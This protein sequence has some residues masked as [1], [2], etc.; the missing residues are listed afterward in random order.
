TQSPVAGS[1]VGIGTHTISI[2]VTDQ[3]GNSA[4]CSTTLTVEDNTAPEISSASNLEIECDAFGNFELVAEW[5]ASVTA[6]DNCDANVDVTASVDMETLD[7]T[8]DNI[9][10]TTVTW[11]ATDDA[12]NTAQTSAVLIINDARIPTF[13]EVVD[14]TVE[15]DGMGNT[16]EFEMF[17]SQ[18]VID[19][20]EVTLNLVQTVTEGCGL[21]KSILVTGTATYGNDNEVSASATFHIIDTT[22][23]TVTAPADIAIEADENC[24]WN[25]MPVITGMAE[26]SDLCSEEGSMDESIGYSDVV[27]DLG[28]GEYQITRTWTASDECGNSA[29]DQQVI[30]VTGGNA[31]PVLVLNEIG[32]YLT[33]EGQWTLNQHNI[34]AIT[35]GSEA[36]CGSED[37]LK[38][39]FSQRYFD[40]S[41]VF[42][43]IKLVVTA[44]DTKGNSSSGSIFINVYDTIAPVAICKDTTIYLDSFGQAMIVP[45]AVN[46]GGDRESVP[47]WARH[48]NDLEGGSYDACGIALM[49]LSQMIFTCNDLGENVVTLTVWD[50]SGNF[51]TCQATVTVLDTITPVFEPIANVVLTVEPGVC[52]T[53]IDYPQIVANDNCTVET[54]LMAGHGPEGLF[55]LGTTTEVWKV[56]D[57]SGNEAFMSFT[58]TVNTYNAAPTIAEI[59][60]IVVDEDPILIEIPLTN[61]TPNV[62]CDLQQII[63]VEASTDNNTLITGLELEYT[64][65]ETTGTLLVTVEPN[66]NGQAT[67]SITVKDNGGTE[68]GGSDTTVET[69]TITVVPVPDMPEV[70]I[71]GGTVAIEPGQPVHIDLNDLFTNPDDEDGLTFEVTLPDGSP[72]P[73]WVEFDPETGI[74][75]GTPGEGDS[76]VIEVT[77]IA[78]NSAGDSVETTVTVI[79]IEEETSVINGT[80]LTPDGPASAGITVAL[81]SVGENN[82]HT[83]VSQVNV[84]ANGSFTFYNVANGTYLI[85]AIVTDEDLHPTLF[86]TWYETAL[87]VLDA[88]A[89]VISQPGAENIQVTMVDGRQQ[90]G[91]FTAGGTIIVKVNEDDPGTP[92]AMVEVV[93]KQDGIIVATTMTDEDGNFSFEGLPEGSYDVFVEIPGYD[94]EIT[95]TI[96]VNEDSP[97]V[98]DIDF[99]IWTTDDR[100]ITDVEIVDGSFDLKMYPN[101]TQGMVNI[102]LID[103]NFS[104]VQVTV[105]NVLGARV[106][107][108]EYPAGDRIQFNMNGNVSGMYLVKIDTEGRSAVKKLMLD[109]K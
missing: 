14:L 81:F 4:F 30:T 67:V 99:T 32:I 105:Y 93:L 55:P 13:G 108:R 38:F 37:D 7:I 28:Q 8:C 29:S 57:A 50:P 101:P 3:A 78:T 68:N 16:E 102:E 54:H 53:A 88:T 42:E 85:K 107:S 23:P 12:G 74:I 61:I 25:A 64:Q 97:E 72:L 21:T 87:S 19:D 27:V 106:F 45:G 76:G 69:F 59:E 47:E 73:E 63:S 86:H 60:D 96:V 103:M 49:D 39:D 80:V 2:T 6:T 24:E 65:G 41:D 82:L 43:P 77:I 109:L 26:V 100:I 104:K 22:P 75:S 51:A 34:A 91:T 90:D 17:L 62:D 5:L 44:S 89:I 94:Q 71:P 70:V 40:C 11:T 83:L 33:E 10:E 92:A 79:I 58:V 48:H 20:P 35:A 18:F 1:V 31:P 52:E 36:G 46:Q 98:T 15:C 9:G 66:L 84:A 56:A 95:A